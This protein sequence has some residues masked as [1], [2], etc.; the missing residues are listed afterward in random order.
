[1]FSAHSSAADDICRVSSPPR[2]HFRAMPSPD[3]LRRASLPPQHA[4]A[5]FRFRVFAGSI[6]LTLLLSH[7]LI[8]FERKSALL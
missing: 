4:A 2:L 6:F 7:F 3:G 1:M 8:F 5:A